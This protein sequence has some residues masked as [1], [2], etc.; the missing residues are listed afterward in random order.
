[1]VFQRPNPFPKSIHDNAAW[2]LKV[3]GM[4]D[5]LEERVERAADAGRSLGRGQGP[6]EGERALTLRR[7]AATP[8]H[9]TRHRRRAGRRVDGRARIVLSTRLRQPQSSS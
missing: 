3:L 9:R 2:G 7:A 6:V 8:L 4:K 1:M 5:R